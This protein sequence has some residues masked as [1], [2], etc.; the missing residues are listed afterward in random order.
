[1]NDAVYDQ[2]YMARHS[3]DAEGKGSARHSMKLRQVG[4]I[5]RVTGCGSVLFA[6]A[7]CGTEIAAARELDLH[8][9]GFD[10][11]DPPASDLVRV[12]D[13]VDELTWPCGQFDVLA[14][15]DVFEHL[16]EVQ[17][18]MAL[19]GIANREFLWV[20]AAIATSSEHEGHITLRALDWWCD[21]FRNRNYVLVAEP[22]RILPGEE[23]VYGI[24]RVQDCL[25]RNNPAG[26]ILFWMLR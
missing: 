7:A 25:A 21:R 26:A 1:M 22:S 5:K 2:A 9:E 3:Y 4:L 6:G 10:V 20:A 8:A 11:C 23:R 14:V 24:A 13:L 18:S 17:V 12:G 16:T 15:I 19:D